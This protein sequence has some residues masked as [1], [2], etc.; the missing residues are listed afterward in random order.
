V[1]V[2]CHSVFHDAFRLRALSTKTVGAWKSSRFIA[3][4]I[5]LQKAEKPDCIFA[6]TSKQALAHFA[7][8][9][10]GEKPSQK[11]KEIVLALGS[12]LIIVD[13]A[14]IQK[15]DV[16]DSVIVLCDIWYSFSNFVPIL[17]SNIPKKVE[18]SEEFYHQKDK[19]AVVPYKILST[20]ECEKFLRERYPELSEEVDQLIAH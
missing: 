3:N 8:R 2:L 17:V 4:F 1:L 15:L 13:N 10:L 11:Q 6:I 19:T 9:F 16:D 18:M 7:V 12:S 14:S 5:I 20:A